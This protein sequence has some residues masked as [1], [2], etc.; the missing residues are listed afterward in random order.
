M[1]R[2]PRPPLIHLL[3]FAPLLAFSLAG[4]AADSGAVPAAEML[5]FFPGSVAAERAAE[6]AFLAVP[7]PRAASDWLFRLTQTVHLA[8]TPTQEV[9]TDQVQRGFESLRDGLSQEQYRVERVDYEVF[10]NY[11]RK[12]SLRLVEPVEKELSLTQD[13]Y[14]VD[15]SSTSYGL[16]PTFHGYGYPGKV[17]GKVVYVNYG[18]P[19]DY[20][21]LDQLRITLAGKVALARYGNTLRGTI[22]EQ[23]QERGALG[24]L[25]FSDPADTGYDIED[26]YP[27]GPM[28]PATGIEYGSVEYAWIV[29]GDPSTP[30][31]SSRQPGDDVP[32]VPRDEMINMPAIP[33]LPISYATATEILSRLGGP[34]VPPGWQGGLPF[35]Y[36]VGPGGAVVEMDVDLEEGYRV[37]SNVFAVFPGAEDSPERDQVILL[38]NHRDAW[39]HGATD[40]N[41]GTAIQL[42]TARGLVA[43]IKAG[44]KPRRTIRIAN[45]DAEEYGLVGSTEYGEQFHDALKRNGVAYIG[46]DVAI[47]GPEFA[48]LGGTPSLRD[49]L[50]EVTG[51]LPEPRLGGT[52]AETWTSR[53]QSEWASSGPVSVGHSREPFDLLLTPPGSGSDYT[54]YLDHLGIPMIDYVFQG[55][56]GVYHTAYDTYHWM[57][58]YGDPGFIYHALSTRFFGL[59]AMRLAAADVVPYR[60]SNYGPSLA[61]NLDALKTQT[62][63]SARQPGAASAADPPLLDPDFAPVEKAL[64]RFAKACVAA[65]RAVTEFLES[66]APPAEKRQAARRLTEILL[67]VERQ[68][69]NEDGLPLPDGPGG[70]KRRRPWY[71]HQLYAPGADTGYASSPFPG[72]AQAIANGDQQ[73]YRK[74]VEKVV[75]AL[76]KGAETLEKAVAAAR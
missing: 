28:K 41:S 36:H 48:V 11:P 60:F 76:V 64:D 45:W 7:A 61:S 68:F 25:V 27:G 15:K 56:Y 2:H 57:A 38:G 12:T 46:T 58:T 66:P 70:E 17:Q 3:V 26:V 69:L 31:Y 19:E 42:E 49:L 71:K 53:R 29:P 62:V 14:D 35:A 32:R 24:V 54:V 55:P 34:N 47:T 9:V 16:P 51:E 1:N 63:R 44:W 74:Q 67:S 40:P 50:L 52:L 73:S 30:G 72:V 5:G 13:S 8:G 18:S 59:L 39:G 43:A 22:V 65:D 4:S 21:Q 20:A 10:L 33:S 75:E 23:A 6:R 37:I